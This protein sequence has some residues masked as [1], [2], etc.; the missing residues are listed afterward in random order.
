MV[1]VFFTFF[2]LKN[3]LYFC[4]FFSFATE[5]HFVRDIKA[6]ILN[7][8]HANDQNVIKIHFDEN[9]IL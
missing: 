1:F 8:Q 5:S 2:K 9:E 7:Q 6:F 3:V 4:L